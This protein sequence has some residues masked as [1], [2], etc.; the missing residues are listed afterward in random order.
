MPKG[1]EL[2]PYQEHLVRKLAHF[3]IDNPNGGVLNASE[4][5]TGKTIMTLA[6]ANLLKI[7]RDILILCPAAVKGVWEMEVRKFLS[8]RQ[9]TIAA[10]HTSSHVKDCH[11][12]KV[13]IASYDLAKR[14]RV[15]R[16]LLQRKK[17]L[18][19]LDEAHYIRNYSTRRYKASM[20]LWD[21]ARYRVCLTGTPFVTRIVDGYTLFNACDPDAFPNFKDFVN[22]YSY[23]RETP[24]SIDYYG[25]KN[26]KELGERIRSKFYVRVTKEEV[27]PDLPPRT[28]QMVPLP[29][30]YKVTEGEDIDVDGILDTIRDNKE[31]Q[32]A[33]GLATVRRLQGVKKLPAVEGF[34]QDLLDQDLPVVVFTY[35]TQVMAGLKKAFEQY[36]PAVIDGSVPGQKRTAEVARFQDGGTNLFI[37]QVIAAGTGITLHRSSITIVVEPVWEPGIL[38]QALDRQ[39]RIGQKNPVTVYFLC[40]K[41]SL[42][43]KITHTLIERERAITAVLET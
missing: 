38:R 9:C 7:K 12:A 40:V 33:S 31:V 18:L 8:V 20:R 3:L 37:G 39:H 14:E 15:L 27:L 13:I 34:I 5:G 17:T 28:Y 21:S 26:P 11:D 10:L 24:W 42:D 25:V 4:Q 6:L 29:E 23:Q 41:G 32:V 43:E 35:H 2:Y 30:E 36:S 16:V 1:V 22:R 19:V